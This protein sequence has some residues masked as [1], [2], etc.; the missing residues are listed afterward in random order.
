MPLPLPS[1]RYVRAMEFRTDNPQRAS[2]RE[3]RR[4][5]D[6][7]VSKAGSRRRRAGLRGDAGGRG[8]QRLRLVAGQGAVH[9]TG[10]FGVDARS[11]QRS[12]GAAAHAAVR[13]AGSHPAEHRTVLHRHAAHACA[14]GHH[15]AIEDH[16]YSCRPAGLHDRGQLSASRR[17]RRAERLSARALPG[18]GHEGIRD[19]AGRQRSNGC[20][21]SKR[22]TSTGRTP[23]A[24]RRRCSCPRARR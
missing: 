24:T 15:A 11:R 6:P 12:R 13:Q 3:R 18:D 10:G 14:A 22:G 17:H 5:S 7:R 21:G 9:G 4:R 20:S 8:S 1:T 19:A 23:T 2:S 16:R